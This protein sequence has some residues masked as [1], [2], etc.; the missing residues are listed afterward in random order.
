MENA[1]TWTPETGAPCVLPA[2]L[3]TASGHDTHLFV[4]TVWASAQ[5]SWTVILLLSQ[6]WQVCRQMTTLEVAN[7]GRYGFMGGR[8]GA[9][10]RDQSGAVAAMQS[11]VAALGSGGMGAGGLGEG[12]GGGEGTTLDPNDVDDDAGRPPPS[13]SGAAGSLAGHAHAGGRHGHAHGPCRGGAGGGFGFLL[14]ILGLDRFTRGK[15]AAGLRRAG[16]DANPFDQ[17][18]VVVRPLPSLLASA[19]TNDD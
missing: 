13:R 17:G 14:Q 1:P 7:L 19:E 18:L 8:G 3:C 4:V 12:E 10:L 11:H 6:A 9:S 16:R 5:L 15:A 2:A